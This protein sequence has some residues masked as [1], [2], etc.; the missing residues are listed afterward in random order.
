ML[1]CKDCGTS[2]GREDN[3]RRHKNH[4]C[5][6]GERGKTCESKRRQIM[7]TYRTTDLDNE[8][9]TFSDEIPTFDGD[10]FCG[11]KPLTHPTLNRIMKMMKMPEDRWDQIATAELLER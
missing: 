2:F 5:K 8:T 3:L 7:K 1:S 9:S 11:N 10:E 4:H 6:G